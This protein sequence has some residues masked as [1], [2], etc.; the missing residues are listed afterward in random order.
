MPAQ[1]PAPAEAVLDEADTVTSRS[2]SMRAAVNTGPGAAGGG[3]APAQRLFTISE[4]MLPVVMEATTNGVFVADAATARITLV[5]S[6]MCRMLGYGSQ[7]LV[8]RDFRTLT[9]GDRI[10]E[11]SRLFAAMAA[12]ALVEPATIT[13]QRHNGCALPAT[14]VGSPIRAHGRRLAVGILHDVSPQQRAEASLRASE[15]KLRAIFD[16]VTDGIIV[17]DL[18]TGG[19]AEVNPRICELLGY[20]RDEMLALDIDAISADKSAA[21]RARSLQHLER[22]AAGEPQTFEWQAQANDGRA[23]WVEVSLRRVTL[24]ERD[25][26]L[27]TA[28]DI[29]GRKQATEALAYRDQL[30]HATTLGI[31]ELVGADGLEDGMS[32]ALRIVGEALGVDRVL[33]IAEEGPDEAPALR[34]L[35]EGPD[36]RL[37][38][39]RTPLGDYPVDPAAIAAWRAPLRAGEQVITHAADAPQSLQGMLRWLGNQSM[40]LVPIFVGGEYWGNIGL[41]SCRA[42]R[43]WNVTDAEVL[44]T[45]S[46][47]IGIVM[48]RNRSRLSLERSEAQLSDA[49]NMARAGGWEYEVDTGLFTFNDSFYRVLHTTAAEVGGYRMGAAEYVRRFVHPEDAPLIAREL[50]AAQHA[51]DPGYNRELE[52]RMLYADGTSGHVVVRLSIVKD[53]QGRTIRTYGVNQDVTERKRVESE[54]QRVNRAFKEAMTSTVQALASTLERRDPYT[55]GHQREVAKLATAIAARLGIGEADRD[56]I[57]LASIIHDIGKIQVPAEI[58][59]KPGRLTPLEYQI[60]QTHAQA[61]YEIVKGVD[62]PWPIAEMIFQHHERLDGSG[63]PRGLKEGQIII[64]ARILAV[65]DVVESMMAHRPYRAA[66]GL[67][68]ALAEI[69]RGKGVRYDASVVDACVT[70]LRHG[71]LGT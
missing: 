70:V 44:H 51:V 61:G 69:E 27:S 64:G 41:D 68:Q 26:L 58:L 55:A 32:R 20:T 34:H 39:R 13:L 40:L 5:N 9:A 21:G 71:G 7:E 53:D 36:A 15:A 59:S 12:G 37:S 1:L 4:S 18:D 16:S 14:L 46:T 25:F 24:G 43:E 47:V 60:V 10:A 22:A 48:L 56:G 19:F 2:A 38:L 63:Y 31:A 33:V 65:A 50:E 57:Y 6:S 8:G 42:R 28:H 3:N 23:F 45:F 67:D 54:L 62:F 66:L 30:L 52:H 35:W 49:L 11:G 29:T 17:H